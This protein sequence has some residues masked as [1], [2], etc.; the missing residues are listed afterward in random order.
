MSYIIY[1]NYKFNLSIIGSRLDINLTE[2]NLL[3]IYECSVEEADIYVKPIK[4]FYS[5][6]EKSLNKDPNY[7]LIITKCIY[8]NVF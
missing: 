7:N 4:K 6:I 2:T 8:T 1:N 3:D 5:M